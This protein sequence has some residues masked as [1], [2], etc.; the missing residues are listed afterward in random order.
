[1]KRSV[2]RALLSLCLLLCLLPTGALGTEEPPSPAGTA[3]T[4]TEGCSLEAGHE[5]ACVLHEARYQTVEGG[6]W[7]YDD[8]ADACAS[9]YEGGTVEVLRDLE[10]PAPVTLTKDMTLTSADPE[11]PCKITY[12]AGKRSNY[13]LTVSA[14]VTLADLILDGGWEAGLATKAELV[15]VKGGQLTLDSGAILQNNNNVNKNSGTS[16]DAGGLRV[17]D[18]A[19]VMREG[20]FIR[21]CRGVTG[22]GA[23]MVGEKSSFRLEGGVIE[24]CEAIVGGGIFIQGGGVFAGPG[25]YEDDAHED[26]HELHLYSGA[27]RR[28][29]ASK[30]LDGITDCHTGAIEGGGGGV[31]V[32]A[33]YQGSC[34]V[35]LYG[36]SIEEN[37]AQYGGGMYIY[38][39]KVH[40]QGG[41]ITGNHA[42]G[43]GGGIYVMLEMPMYPFLKELVTEGDII[44]SS[45]AVV[46]GNTCTDKEGSETWK[47]FYNV[48]LDGNDDAPPPYHYLT[49]P[50]TVA[51]PLTEGTSIG[52]SGWSRP[53]ETHPYRVVARPGEGYTITTDDLDRF[54]S[55]DPRYVTLLHND[56]EHLDDPDNGTVVLTHA[57]VAFD[58]QGHGKRP[59]S[60]LIDADK[61]VTKPQDP[62]E[63]GY[64]FESWYVEPECE[65]EWKFEEDKVETDE[66]PQVLYAK[67]ELNHYKIEYELEGGSAPTTAN[68]DDYTIESPDITLNEPTREGYAFMGWKLVAV[69]AQAVD[70]TTPLTY[71][72]RSAAPDIPAGSIGKRTFEAQWRKLPPYTVTY[73]DGVEDVQVFPDQV[74]VITEE[75]AATPAF[76]GTPARAGYTFAGWEPEVAGTVTDD[77][78]YVAQWV[79]DPPAPSDDDDN[80]D[81][82][83]VKP[84]AVPPALESA[85][86][87]AYVV[88]YPDGRVRPEGNITRAEAAAIFFR[89]MTEEFREENRAESCPFPDV[90]RGSWYSSAVST[91]VRAGLIRGLP[92]GTFGGDRPIARAEF[93]AMAARFLSEETA[94]E[95]GFADLAGHWA[96]DEVD[97]AVAAGWLKGYP[98]GNFHPEE[99][100]TR[101][102]VMAL[103]NRMLGRTPDTEG[104]RPEMVRWPDCPEGAW[105]YADVQE[106]TNSHTYE[107]EGESGPETW[108]GLTPGRDWT[109]PEG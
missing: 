73:T 100:I 38:S 9:V 74:T 39:G 108:T 23:A 31:C 18:G 54:Y 45:G 28:N 103:V 106:A 101:A 35:Y 88:G 67:W 83:P 59:P 87:F 7:L 15:G 92:D 19:V 2:I 56:L 65:T 98:D 32:E 96:Q 51:G 105:Y 80:D 94:P 78:V 47:C 79:K 16:Q 11:R 40:L 1:M 49:H 27:I 13:F 82:P 48:C 55:D 10:Q 3:C 85:E 86:H 102:Q 26:K 6:E 37:T 90:G 91:C 99:Y 76:D 8:L 20:S 109:G 34:Q 66:K 95:S 44:L 36:A 69:D 107:R 25:P 30:T 24:D 72:A 52:V 64:T 41:A 63:P 46:D 43:M 89:L 29:R 77:A 14:G 61:L 5:G 42:E 50:M 12:T 71:S 4:V 58:N 62:V 53:D 68:P 70:H 33:A 81:D 22:G 84:P 21:S 97:R 93:A 57:D 60:Q 104:M 75:N 17:V